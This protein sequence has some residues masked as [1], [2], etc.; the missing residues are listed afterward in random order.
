VAHIT[1]YP[2]PKGQVLGKPHRHF[3][4]L[5]EVRETKGSGLEK[6]KTVHINRHET[7]DGNDGEHLAEQ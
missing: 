2:D 7:L 4:F 5:Q 6:G 1:L 3:L